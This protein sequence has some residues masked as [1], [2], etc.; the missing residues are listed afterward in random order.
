MASARESRDPK[1]RF[2]TPKR[3]MIS[4]IVLALVAAFGAASCNKTS[5][6]NSKSASGSSVAKAGGAAGNTPA[7][8]VP[9]PDGL[10]DQELTP[11]DGS[12]FKL[13]DYAGKVVLINLWATWCG[14]C[15]MEMPEL[16]RLSEEYKS[17]GFEV[18]GVTNRRSDPDSRT[19]RDF[20]K[21]E[22]VT[23]RIVWDDGRLEGPLVQAVTGG[24]V[25][26]QS[27]LISRDG[28]IVKHFKGYNPNFTPGKLRE[29]IEQALVDKDGV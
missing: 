23:Y 27:F 12:S 22:N 21:A 13:S 11:L 29:A 7:A 10:K 17:Q 16:V 28:R 15:R 3:T 20:L 9:M 24:D 25:I 6:S 4:F 18:I 26:P 2:W 8:F 1:M 19:I 5:E 14:P